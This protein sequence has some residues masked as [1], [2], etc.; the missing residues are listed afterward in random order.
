[1]PRPRRNAN[2]ADL[3][4]LIKD[5]AWKQISE[6][7]SSSLS[8]RAIAREL[9]ITAP[10]IY[11]YF[12][13]KDDLVTALIIEA[14]TSFGD[15]QLNARDHVSSSDP[16]ERLKAIGRA[17]RT[18]AVQNPQRYQLIFGTPIPGYS[19]PSEL[20]MPSAVRSLSALVSVLQQ[21]QSENKLKLDGFPG[22]TPGFETSFEVWERFGGEVELT[23][24]SIGILFWTQVHGLVSLEIAGNLPPYGPAGDSLFEYLLDML[25]NNF[26]KP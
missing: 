22:L 21:L 13:R 6:V 10:A 1:M 8:L 5:A 19:A 18:W 16:A 3:K 14:Y 23:S 15:S 12:P 20:T 25:N 7:G 17:Y 24:I 9:K 26:I 4:D 2:L 11:N